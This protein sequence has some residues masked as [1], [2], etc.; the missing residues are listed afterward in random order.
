MGVYD[1]AGALCSAVVAVL[2]YVVVYRLVDMV[3]VTIQNAVFNG[4]LGFRGS[5]I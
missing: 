2:P 3:L 5:K 1:F 4:Q